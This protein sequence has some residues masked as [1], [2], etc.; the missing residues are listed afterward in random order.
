MIRPIIR[1]KKAAIRTPVAAR[2]F[3][4]PILSR[5]SRETSSAKNSIEE[6][7]ASAESTNPETIRIKDHSSL[8]I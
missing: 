6:L 4:F 8:V 5:F 7:K 3:A 2:S 1:A